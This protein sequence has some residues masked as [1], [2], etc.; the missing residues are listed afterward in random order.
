ML[1][2]DQVWDAIDRLAHRSN[3]TVSA[4]AKKAGLDPTTFN[5]S[6]RY[7]VDGRHRWPSTES[8]SKILEATSSS[9]EDFFSPIAT[10]QHSLAPS[11]PL[12]G[13]AQAGNN[14]FFDDGG[15]P[16]GQGWDEVAFPGITDASAY[17]LEISGDSLLPVYRDGDIVIASPTAPFRRGD[18][19]IVR[20]LQGE[21][22]TKELRRH[23]SKMTELRSL[24]PDYEDRTFAAEEIS[25]IARIIW[26][27]Q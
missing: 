8:I 7:N 18:R 1:T 9:V 27:S 10:N 16:T 14:E 13:F 3:M 22:L 6:K 17:A 24:N 15:F 25:W 26:C 21:I 12:L 2:H 11:L 20:T 4:L 19:V 23:T 5:R